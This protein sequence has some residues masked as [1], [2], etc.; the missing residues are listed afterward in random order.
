MIF[1][2]IQTAFP[3]ISITDMSE[4]YDHID[5]FKNIYQKN[6]PGKKLRTQVLAKMEKE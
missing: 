6:P 4:M 2:D 3:D 1:D 5:R